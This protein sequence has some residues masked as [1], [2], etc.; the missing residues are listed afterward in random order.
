MWFLECLEERYSDW[1]NINTVG[2]KII[3]HLESTFFSIGR[4]Y[5]DDGDDDGYGNIIKGND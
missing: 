3:E 5:Y 1:E 4:D 2:E